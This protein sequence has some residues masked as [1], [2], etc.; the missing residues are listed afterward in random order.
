MTA[1][2]IAIS[3]R[4]HHDSALPEPSALF[5]LGTALMLTWL[6]GQVLRGVVGPLPLAISMGASYVAALTALGVV[7]CLG[8]ARRFLAGGVLSV[9]TGQSN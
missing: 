4:V 1:A 3:A 8:I 7:D 2:M 6:C 5:R 9:S